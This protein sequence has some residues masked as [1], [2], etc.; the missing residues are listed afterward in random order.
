[1]S[2]AAT[3]AATIATFDEDAYASNLATELDVP[4]ADISLAVTAASVRVVATV[5]VA[6]TSAAAA[7]ETAVAALVAAP[8]DVASDRLGVTVEQME[9]PIT[10]VVVV[11]T[12]SLPP[13]PL[14]PPSPLPMP[15]PSDP[16]SPPRP[17]SMPNVDVGEESALVG[18][19][20]D[21]LSATIISVIIVV[22][23]IVLLG[24]ALVR[25]LWTQKQRE[26]ELAQSASQPNAATFAPPISTTGSRAI[27]TPIT[28]PP[29]VEVDLM[30][31]PGRLPESPARAKSPM[32]VGHKHK[33]TTPTHGTNCI[34]RV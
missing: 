13:P 30:P 32:P 22:V 34:A 31:T 24:F 12:P 11:P 20:G 16:P 4:V 3:I 8:A 19:S 2:F 26:N 21:N 23:L 29:H 14:L 1:M 7:V 33:Q 9:E 5:R 28:A 25:L 17:P 6:A 15:L 10:A 27:A 18:E